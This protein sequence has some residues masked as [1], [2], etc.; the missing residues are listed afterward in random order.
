MWDR[1]TVTCQICDIP[2][3]PEFSPADKYRNS[4]HKA[5][6]RLWWPSPTC[7]C[8]LPEAPGAQLAVRETYEGEVRCAV[9]FVPLFLNSKRN[10]HSLASG[11][12]S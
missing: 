5:C 2:V 3:I 7:T 12:S 9:A 11:F 8:D 10:V 6:T 4:M 1:A